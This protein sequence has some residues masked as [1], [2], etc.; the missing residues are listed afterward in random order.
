MI[1]KNQ[2][3]LIRSLENKKY[4]KLNGLFVA[5]GRKV[6][7]EM[8]SAN[9]PYQHIYATE[10]SFLN[11]QD[12]PVSLIDEK[13][14]AKCSFLKTPD[15]VLA[16]A[17]LP[18]PHFDGFTQKVNLYLDGIRDPGNLGTIIR[19]ADWYGLK[20]IYCSTDCVDAFNPKTVQASMGSIF[21]ISVCYLD[22]EQTKENLPQDLPV[23]GAVMNGDNIHEVDIET[24]C[25]LIIGNESNGIRDFGENLLSK[26]ISIPKYGH[27]ESLN[28]ALA[29]GILLDK[30]SRA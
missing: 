2:Q 5:E 10:N 3:K 8:L 28:A 6:V 18:T 21:R 4:R 17:K 20:Q 15:R 22:N 13:E 16:I 14:L 7:N 9:F 26:R 11:G 23:Y 30:F 1:S 27:A 12:V 19:L 29:T 25:M 24:P